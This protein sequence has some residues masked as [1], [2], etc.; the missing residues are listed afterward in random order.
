M[1]NYT[2]DTWTI[3]KITGA[4]PHYRVFGSWRG[5]YLDGDSW[6]MNSGIVSVS[7]DEHG[8]FIFK[9]ETGSEYRCHKESYGIRSTHNSAV[10]ESYVQ[11]SSGFMENI[12]ELPDVM[13]MD[14][15]ISKGDVDE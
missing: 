1:S 2:P 8:Y 10:L 14:W 11:K 9:G 12:E 6:R 15:I 5:G 7:E 4:T 3:V 13:N